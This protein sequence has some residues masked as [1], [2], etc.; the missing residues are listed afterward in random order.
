MKH[1]EQ[2]VS[3]HVWRRSDQE[4]AYMSKRKELAYLHWSDITRTW[5]EN[6]ELAKIGSWDINTAAIDELTYGR[7]IQSV[8]QRLIRTHIKP[9]FNQECLGSFLQELEYN[10]LAC[11]YHSSA[12]GADVGHQMFMMVSC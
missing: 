10:Y 3:N 5:P 7:S 2:L 9:D 12:H 8:G 1:H 11:P 6:S 4:R